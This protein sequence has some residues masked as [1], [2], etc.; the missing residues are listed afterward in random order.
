MNEQPSE[1]LPIEFRERLQEIIP[2]SALET[3]LQSFRIEKQFSFRINTLV[4]SLE[5]TLSELETLGIRFQPLNWLKDRGNLPIAYWAERR[6]REPLTHSQ[7]VDQGKI[8]LQ[9]LSSMLA[10]WVLQPAPGDR[11]LDLAAAPGGKTTLL[12]QLM[13]NQGEL[14]AV[15]AI[16]N[17]MFKLKANLKRCGVSICKTYLT[18]GRT[19]GNKTPDRFDLVLLDAPCS[20]EARFRTGEPQS[21]STWSPRKLRE[22]SRKQ[23][24]L[25][26]AAVHAARIGGSVL[27][28]TCSLSPEENEQVVDRVLRNFG[29]AIELQAIQLP[30]QN[31]QSGLTQFRGLEFD[32]QLKFAVRVLPNQLND[33]FFIARIFKRGKTRNRQQ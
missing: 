22:T 6:Y 21:W 30:L 26:K 8:Y 27:Y 9:N 5:Q 32:P 15:E 11:V 29:Q 18:D 17:R 23:I 16:R 13:N 25:L 2:A 4:S 7:L 14:S 19:V 24:G 12:A 1:E 33:A 31:V 10:P 28:C 3:V 20:S